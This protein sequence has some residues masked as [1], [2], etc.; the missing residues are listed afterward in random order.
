MVKTCILCVT[1]VT[2][3]LVACTP[4]VVVQ[5]TPS[6]SEQ[7]VTVSNKVDSTN[8]TLKLPY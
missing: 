2:L 8:V 6:N 1:V 4:L 5:R 3:L 7:H